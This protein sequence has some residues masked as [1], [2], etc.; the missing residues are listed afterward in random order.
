VKRET[1][2][3]LAAKLPSCVVAM[4]ACC[5]AHHLWRVFAAHRHEVRFMSPGVASILSDRAVD[6]AL[7]RFAEDGSTPALTPPELQNAGNCTPLA[8]SLSS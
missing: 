5:G 7:S 2:V 1:L 3:A 8:F 6:S 4:E